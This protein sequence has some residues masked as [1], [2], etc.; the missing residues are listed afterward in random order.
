MKSLLFIINIFFSP[1]IFAQDLIDTDGDGI[2]DVEDHC[3]TVKGPKENNGCQWQEM[4]CYSTPTI[5]FDKDKTEI[6]ESELK[7]LDNFISSF[8]N[9]LKVEDIEKLS[10]ISYTNLDSDKN[11]LKRL[12]KKR[13]ENVKK[14]M[15]KNNK[16][17]K[18]I[19]IELKLDSDLRW[20]EC[21]DEECPEWKL[22]EENRISFGIKKEKPTN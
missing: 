1:I 16:I 17:F 3:P 13:A 12:A 10:I 6:S 21:I 18:N 20:K 4:I 19:S 7:Q 5:Y 11:K 9:S 8:L 14:Y 15:I 22:K 2:P